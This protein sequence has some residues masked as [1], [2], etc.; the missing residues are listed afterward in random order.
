MNWLLSLR[1]PVF[2]D[3]WSSWHKWPVGGT[4]TWVCH[5]HQP[6]KLEHWLMASKGILPEVMENVMENELGSGFSFP[7]D[8]HQQVSSYSF[9]KV[10]RYSSACKVIKQFCFRQ[11]HCQVQTVL[12][13][14]IITYPWNYKLLAGRPKGDSKYRTWFVLKTLRK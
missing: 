7:T 6:K 12:L 5:L 11:R 3:T 8:C 1:L 2:E 13:G 9:C 10:T 14:K 4:E